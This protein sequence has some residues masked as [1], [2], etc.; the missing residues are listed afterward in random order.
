M[1]LQDLQSTEQ[2]DAR[3]LQ[4]LF[5]MVRQ[6]CEPDLESFLDV[7]D[8]VVNDVQ[9]SD[10]PLSQSGPVQYIDAKQPESIVQLEKQD[11]KP[12]L[13]NRNPVSAGYN[14]PLLCIPKVEYESL[15]SNDTMMERDFE[16]IQQKYVQNSLSTSH[17]F[18]CNELSQSSKDYM[19]RH[20]LN[21]TTKFLDIDR[22][23]KLPKLL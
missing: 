17:H 23:Q 4:D 13:M 2:D 12:N 11:T 3:D 5:E 14:I 16:R 20:Q 10:I 6:V 1:S 18:Y 15:I 9:S 8:G 22:I 21:E 19:Q 7:I